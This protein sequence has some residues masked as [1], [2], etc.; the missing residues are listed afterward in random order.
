MARE[1]SEDRPKSPAWTLDAQAFDRLLAAL[2]ADRERAAIAYEGLRRR[3]IALFHWWG[4]SPAED[5]ADGTLDRV[6]RKIAEGAVIPDASLGAFVRGVARLIVLEAQRR[7][8]AVGAAEQIAVPSAAVGPE[9]V[10]E[11]LD[12]SLDRLSPSDRTLVLGYYG[13][14]KAADNR[15][16][17]AEQ[18]EISPSALRIR[19]MR[20]RQRLEQEVADEVAGAET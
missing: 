5:L 12:R 17:L 9:P 13:E 18:L 3:L 4:A 7:S 20:I 19:A 16:K 14:G 6:A 15:R 10:L 11:R 2:D 8:R 1:C